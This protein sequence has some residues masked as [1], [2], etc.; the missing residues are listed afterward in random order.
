MTT[1]DL[2]EL[3]ENGSSYPAPPAA[4]H[5]AMLEIAKI[6]CD[7]PWMASVA[8]LHRLTE[9]YGDSAAVAAIR[10]HRDSG[11]IRI[12]IGRVNVGGGDSDFE[13]VDAVVPTD[14]LPS[15]WEQELSRN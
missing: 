5:P 1:F 6:L 9:D 2:G 4:V 3:L 10:E 14:K 13:E 11:R 7:H 8:L 15:W 12:G